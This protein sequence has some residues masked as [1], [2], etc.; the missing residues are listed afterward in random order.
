MEYIIDTP[1]GK[2]QGIDSNVEGVIAFKGIRYATSERF[3]YPKIIT[4]WEGIYDAK[5]YKHCAYQPRS[6][7]D[8]EKNVKKVFYYNE[9]RKG[10]HY[11]Y[12]EDC[13]FLNIWTPKEINKNE[14]LPVIIYI[15]GGGFKSGCG[16]ELPFDGP[17][18]PL[19]GVIA[20]TI[21]YRL[22]PLGF[23]TLKE[24]KDKFGQSG[25]YGLYDQMT[26]IEWIK[27]NIE[28]FGGDKD[29]ITIMG[30]SAGAMSVHQLCSSPLVE[31][32]FHKAVMNSGGGINKFLVTPKEEKNYAFWE[33]VKE[34][35][36]CQTL[37]DLKTVP[38]EILYTAW[39]KAKKEVKGF[40]MA[41]SPVIDGKIIVDT[42]NNIF[43]SNQ[44]HKIP[45]MIGSTSEDMFSPF[46]CNMAKKWSDNQDKPSYCWMFNHPLPGDDNGAW[47]SS[48]LWY[49]FGTLKNCWRPMNEVDYKLSHQMISY[50][51]NFAKSGNPNSND[52]P[53]WEVSNKHSKKVMHFN[54]DT[55][56]QKVNKYKLWNN[57]FTRK[58]VG[59]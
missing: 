5:E 49:F 3:E 33:K 11:T 36:N 22:G 43:K 56:M 26:A 29:N 40:L 46:M 24:L 55:K 23:I 45:Y 54:K 18:W 27:N 47:H 8:E 15:H 58:S 31:G 39:E 44:Q 37:D 19:Y 30:Q 52:L 17:L 50:L 35:A 21:N 7:Y 12:S 32:L 38:V 57:L 51:T 48:E 25:N 34:F 42:N 10:K 4:N 1:C 53:Y 41:A 59:E 6:F 13:L 16:H 20:V 2:V 28:S 14:K 9:F